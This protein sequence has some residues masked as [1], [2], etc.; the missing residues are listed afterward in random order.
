MRNT[1]WL[2][3]A[4]VAAAI[5]TA[6]VAQGAAE[7]ELPPEQSRGQV[8]F[9]SGGVGTDQQAAMKQV[10]EG[11]PLELQFIE[12]LQGRSVFTAGVEVTIRDR[13][14]SVVLDVRSD[15]P[16]LL[17]KLPPGRYTISADNVGKIETREVIIQPGAH[18][19]VVFEWRA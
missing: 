6:S 15:G 9:M 2:L 11:Y 17:A 5:C 7:T 8:T 10:A 3:G 19:T 18:R 13:A 16:L 14:G 12:T 1:G 4:S